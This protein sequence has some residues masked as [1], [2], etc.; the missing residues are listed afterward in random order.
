MD[1][2]CDCLNEKIDEPDDVFNNFV[3]KQDELNLHD[4]NIEDYECKEDSLDPG[5]L[6]NICFCS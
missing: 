4:N 3:E 6:R 2:I 1:E 5:R